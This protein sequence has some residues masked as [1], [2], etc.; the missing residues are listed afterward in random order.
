MIAQALS[1]ECE[2][3]ILD[4]PCSAL[5]YKNQ[6]IVVDILR[7][8]NSRMGLTIVWRVVASLGGTLSVESEPGQGTQFLVRLPVRSAAQR[9]AA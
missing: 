7:E 5:D 6:S 4:E 1:S 9:G 2:I 8:L 3:L